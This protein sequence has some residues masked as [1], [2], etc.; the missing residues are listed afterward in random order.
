VN[1]APFGSSTGPSVGA[2]FA[3]SRSW[4]AGD[5]VVLQFPMPA[6][7][8]RRT[9]RSVQESQ[10]PDGSPVSQEVLHSDYLAVTRGP[11]V[12]ATDLIDG[13]KV[14]ETLRLEAGPR[15]TLLETVSPAGDEQGLDL[16]LRPAGRAPLTFQPYYRAGGRRDRTW[17]LTWMTLPPE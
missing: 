14:E 1:D 4:S 16:R 2:Y 11:L 10:A 8:H 3:I 6:R 7:T 13:F 15:D 17:R 12:Y 5:T 9:N